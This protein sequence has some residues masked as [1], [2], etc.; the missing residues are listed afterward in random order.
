MHR[1]NSQ[2]QQQQ[3][4]QMRLT[5]PMS[6]PQPQTRQAQNMYNSAQGRQYAQAMYNAQMSPMQSQSVRGSPS[7]SQ[8]SR[9]SQQ[10]AR[11]VSSGTQTTSLTPQEQFRR[12]YAHYNHSGN[13][14]NMG[15]FWQQEFYNRGGTG[16]SRFTSAQ[17]KWLQHFNERGYAKR[18]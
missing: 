17:D 13:P 5:S 4:S 3:R 16:P 18:R 11:G 10:Q 9:S 1:N 14:Q 6:P 12:D 7:G 2:Q 8:S 15:Q